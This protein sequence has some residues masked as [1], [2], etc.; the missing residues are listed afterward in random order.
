MSNL[1]E[2]YREENRKS[3]ENGGS[4][5][6][7]IN[8][9]EE[10]GLYTVS[11]LHGGIDF[12]D[13]RARMA[14]GLTL[15]KDGGIVLRGFSKFFNYKQLELYTMY[16]EDF[17]DKFSRVGYKEDKEV[18]FFEKLDGTL[19]IL[20]EYNNKALVS[21]T[22]S[23]NNPYTKRGLKYF[24]SLGRI[25]GIIDYLKKNDLC[26]CFEW[27]SPMNR[28]VVEYQEDDFVSLAL[29]HK[30]TG[31]RHQLD[32]KHK[33]FANRFGFTLPKEY[34]YKTSEVTKLLQELKGIEGFVLE[35]EYG[36]LIK[37]K[38]E[39]WFKLHH[40]FNI[41]FGF[42]L[43]KGDIESILNAYMED[44]LD[45]FYGFSDYVSKATR[46]VVGILEGLLTDVEDLYKD[47]DKR[48]KLEGESE[49][50]K[51]I[52]MSKLDGFYKALIFNKMKTGE[53]LNKRTSRVVTDYIVEYVKENPFEYEGEI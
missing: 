2:Y 6:F 8:K 18:T 52:G 37:F 44:D 14:R 17:K 42:N 34:K 45:D 32:E 38:T 12:T 25:N 27:V 40:K 19:F 30:E 28:V 10:L 31:E 29:I 3:V 21:T 36:N 53:T 1:L 51:E 41:Q 43:V 4:L 23:I 49:V 46:Y 33:E 9:N 39:E 35:N 47:I 7:K 26:A 15:T 20:G 16:T 5:I 50:R 22:S 48:I 24:N 13:E 11:Y